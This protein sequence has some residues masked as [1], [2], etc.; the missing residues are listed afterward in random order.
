MSDAEERLLR[1]GWD[2]GSKIM[3][4]FLEFET[5]VEINSMKI[6]SVFSNSVF[7]TTCR[8]IHEAS[9]HLKRACK[10]KKF[11]NLSDDELAASKSNKDIVIAKGD[12]ENC[13]VILD[14]VSYIAKAEKILNGNPF[15]SLS[16]K[17][18]QEREKEL[19]KY[20]KEL[21]KE[22]VIDQKLR[23]QTAH[24]HHCRYSMD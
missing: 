10:K 21:L 24:V 8:Q 3:V 7:R 9:G 20:L 19:N 4:D 13:I 5:D 22:K 12:K 17:N 16:N 2:F 6:E 15:Q 18:Y 14:K 23:F 1:H 11:R